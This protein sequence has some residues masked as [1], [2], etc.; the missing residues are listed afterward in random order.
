MATH[1]LFP[2][3]DFATFEGLESDSGI[4]FSSFYDA[5]IYFVY[6]DAGAQKR[7]SKDYPYSKSIFCAKDRDFESG[8]IRGVIPVL[9]EDTIK[10]C[11]CA[12]I[13]DDLCSGGRTFIEV[14][15]ALKATIPDLESIILCVSH[16][17]NT[18]ALNLEEMSGLVNNIFTTNSIFMSNAGMDEHKKAILDANSNLFVV[19]KL[20]VPSK[21][22]AFDGIVNVYFMEEND[23]E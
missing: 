6:P 17:E 20:I 5:G 1:G 16:C 18:V 11:R 15:K 8:K 21:V 19:G 3:P 9:T 22:T 4:D 14:A 13:V 7:Y 23:C 10:T 12:I 2:N